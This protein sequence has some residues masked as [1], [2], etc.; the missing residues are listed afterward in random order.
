MSNN[1]T[2]EH[3]QHINLHNLSWDSWTNVH[4]LSQAAVAEFCSYVYFEQGQSVA[5][6]L[7]LT[8]KEQPVNLSPGH[9]SKIVSDLQL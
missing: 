2:P 9:L 8:G 1:D 4:P 6:N 7:T 3:G 5:Q